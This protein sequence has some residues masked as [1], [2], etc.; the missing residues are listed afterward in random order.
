MTLDD[1]IR[2]DLIRKD[3]PDRKKAENSLK[4]AE[5]NIDIAKKSA[6][7]EAYESAFIS[8]YA[9]MF[10]CARAILFKDGYKERSHYALYVCLK[11]K[12]RDKIEMKYINELNSLR[13][14]RHKIIYGDEDL[15]I[16]EVQESEVES[17]I[18]AAEGFLKSVRKM[19]LA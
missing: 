2:R 1:L 19:I 18:K 11:E 6:E 9:A 7:A 3:A 17:A 10:H 15:N 5:H 4:L 8:A 13:T 14:I 16:R 12:Y